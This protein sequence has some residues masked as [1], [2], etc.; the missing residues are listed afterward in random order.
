MFNR[1]KKKKAPTAAAVLGG[2]GFVLG[3]GA[4]FLFSSEKGKKY[5]NQI[6][7]M[8]ADFLETIAD[9]CK[10]IRKNLSK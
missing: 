10:E 8:T 9:G 4:V 5:R 3:L 2:L 7:E 1:K 6:G